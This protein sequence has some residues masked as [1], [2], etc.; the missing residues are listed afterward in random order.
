MPAE[1]GGGAT[2][3]RLILCVRELLT[4]DGIQRQ[5]LH[6]LRLSPR[7]TRWRLRAHAGSCLIHATRHATRHVA[8]CAGVAS[9]DPRPALELTSSPVK[10]EAVHRFAG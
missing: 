1:N 6:S 5:L 9:S 2:A 3:A 4:T 8:G 10:T 7:S